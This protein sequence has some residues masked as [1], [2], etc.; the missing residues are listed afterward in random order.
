M[1]LDL[2]YRYASEVP[3]HFLSFTQALTFPVGCYTGQSLHL[4][5]LLR[6]CDLALVHTYTRL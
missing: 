4:I 2:L 5:G 1:L 6:S 3:W